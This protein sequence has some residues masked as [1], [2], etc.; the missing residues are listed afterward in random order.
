MTDRY[1]SSLMGGEFGMP[2][3]AGGGS[4]I[5]VQNSFRLSEWRQAIEQ[6]VTDGATAG[7][8]RVDPRAVRRAR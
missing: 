6:T 5:Y 1:R 8:V 4:V 7:R 2:M 3:F